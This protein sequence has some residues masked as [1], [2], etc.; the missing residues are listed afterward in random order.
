MKD[1]L[2]KPVVKQVIVFFFVGGVSSIVEWVL[3][4]IL[5]LGLDVQYLVATV[6]AV[7]CSTF[8]NWFLCKRFVFTE[9]TRFGDKIGKEVAAV[10]LVGF[11][12]M[13]ANLGLM[14]V[15]VEVLGF[16]EVWRK[17]LAK[18]VSTVIVC[19]S[20]FFVKK[21]IIYRPVSD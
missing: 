4:T 10:Y 12:G 2:S 21:F 6:L 20:N 8:V 19:F 16:G 11:A 1:F 15:F 13:L 7:I 14:W 9:K 17:V 18:M 3:F 5:S